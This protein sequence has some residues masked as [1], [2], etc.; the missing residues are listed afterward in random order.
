MSNSGLSELAVI[1]NC[2]YFKHSGKMVYMALDE[3][4]DSA[5]LIFYTKSSS[6]NGKKDIIANG[7]NNLVATLLQ[8]NFH[9]IKLKFETSLDGA[10]F[11]LCTA[12]QTMIFESQ[13]YKLL[14]QAASSDK[15]GS[16]IRIGDYESSVEET[17]ELINKFKEESY[18][19]YNEIVYS[20]KSTRIIG[21]LLRYNKFYSI[22]KSFVPVFVDYDNIYNPY[23]SKE[24]KEILERTVIYQEAVNKNRVIEMDNIKCYM[25]THLEICKAFNM[26]NFVRFTPYFFNMF[27]TG[28]LQPSIDYF[29]NTTKVV[30]ITKSAEAAELKLKSFY[31]EKDFLSLGVNLD[32]LIKSE[33]ALGTQLE[34]FKAQFKLL[35]YYEKKDSLYRECFKNC[36]RLLSTGATMLDGK[37]S[38]V[39]VAQLYSWLSV[40][41]LQYV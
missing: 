9:G 3:A 11:Y 37:E 15:I 31:N 32:D 21:K 18:R 23:K 17:G 4:I 35:N 39:S 8:N 19:L 16:K 22:Q 5:N 12:T 38:K 2:Q 20:E 7:Y 41:T 25:L 28:M 30:Y 29:P 40:A 10:K 26:R 33:R 34:T 13:I 24:C 27:I 1:L 14:R 6:V 36:N